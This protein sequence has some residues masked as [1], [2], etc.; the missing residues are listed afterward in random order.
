MILLSSGFSNESLHS[1]TALNKEYKDVFSELE[2][3][4]TGERYLSQLTKS[5]HILATFN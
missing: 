2:N 4:S 5:G 3:N 1:I